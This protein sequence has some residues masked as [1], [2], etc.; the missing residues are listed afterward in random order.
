MKV[1]R[2]FNLGK[3]KFLLLLVLLAVEAIASSSKPDLAIKNL[4]FKQES[5][6]CRLMVKIGNFGEGVIPSSAYGSSKIL[7]R[8]KKFKEESKEYVYR[9][10]NIDYRKIIQKPHRASLFSIPILVGPGNYDISAYMDVN[11]KIA[12]SNEKNNMYHKPFRCNID[13]S[14]L[15]D[16][17][18]ASISTKV[19]NGKTYAAIKV[20]NLGKEVP[21][22]QLFASNILLSNIDSKDHWHIKMRLSRFQNI[23]SLRYANGSAV[24]VIPKALEVGVNQRYYA[25]VDYNRRIDEKNEKNNTFYTSLTA[26]PEF[27]LKKSPFKIT[28]MFVN[29]QGNINFLVKNISSSPATLGRSNKICIYNNGVKIKCISATKSKTTLLISPGMIAEFKSGLKLNIK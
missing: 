21:K 14:Q 11:H 1:Y 8:I 24:L 6:K 16:L 3:I 18:I 7:I 26:T 19:I 17:K 22:M 23:D 27:K 12:E 2:H 20:K 4:K 15:P 29:N 28:K 10:R 5:G 9:L 25:S 13:T